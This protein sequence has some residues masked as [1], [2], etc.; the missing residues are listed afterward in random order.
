MVRG[1]KPPK[2]FEG[3]VILAALT[4]PSPP[5]GAPAPAMTVRKWALAM[6]HQSNPG[7]TCSW[8]LQEDP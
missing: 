4:L 6:E 1:S 3:L 7:E 5:L 8:T 2:P